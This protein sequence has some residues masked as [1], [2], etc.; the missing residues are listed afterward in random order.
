MITV[1]EGGAIS[2]TG[3]ESIALY[4]L[5][6]LKSAL[7]LE[8]VGMRVNRHVRAFKMAKEEFGLKGNKQ[9]IFDAFCK[10]VEEA[11]AAHTAWQ[12]EQIAK[13]NAPAN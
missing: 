11:G 6:A 12:A 7:R 13:G 4:R 8:M 1:L 3:K 10:I 2:I 5:I 9:Q